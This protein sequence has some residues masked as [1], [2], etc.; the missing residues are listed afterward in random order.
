[1][2]V[3]ADRIILREVTHDRRVTLG[4]VVEA[5][6]YA[7]LE[8]RCGRVGRRC[9]PLPY[10]RPRCVQPVPWRSGLLPHLVE[11]VQRIAN[12]RAEEFALARR[13]V[14]DVTVEVRD[15]L[16]DLEGAI[17]Q[18]RGETRVRAVAGQSIARLRHICR[19]GRGQRRVLPRDRGRQAEGAFVAGL[20]LRRLPE[21]GPWGAVGVDDA[22]GH[23]V[24]YV[25]M[26][27]W[28]VGREYIVK[29]MVLADDHDDVFDRRGSTGTRGLTWDRAR[30]GVR[31]PSA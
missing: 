19:V 15:V 18:A 26:A 11:A 2:V 22:L 10:S 13:R 14:L 17:R 4:H 27:W 3:V 12:I 7:A 25:L 23:Q 21:I 20:E 28:P 8:D 24:Q 31:H 16:G 6:R 9:R 30:L 5:H 1:M 29:A